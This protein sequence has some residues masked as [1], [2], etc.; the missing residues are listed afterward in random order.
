MKTIFALLVLSVSTTAYSECYS[1]Y[2]ESNELVWQGTAAP[3]SMATLS[4]SDEVRKLVP[5]GHMVIADS[6]AAR[7]PAI[8]LIKRTT[9]RQKAEDMKYD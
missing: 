3:V 8:D 5:K 6:D 9:M 4:I 2:S 7:C 1:I